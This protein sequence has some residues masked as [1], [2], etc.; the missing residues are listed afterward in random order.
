M[1]FVRCPT[2]GNEVAAIMDLYKLLVEHKLAGV[3]EEKGIHIKN[4]S[5]APDMKEDLNDVFEAMGIKQSE[6]PL[7]M[8]FT[9]H[10][11]RRTLMLG[12]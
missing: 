7:R 3:A 4:K 8:R 10:V 9:T 11:N 1:A 5:M 2:T 12:Q 6:Y